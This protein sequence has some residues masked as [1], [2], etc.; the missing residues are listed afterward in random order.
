M[1]S[2][3]PSVFGFII[4]IKIWQEDDLLYLAWSHSHRVSLRSFIVDLQ[5]G[6]FIVDLLWER[7]IFP[8]FCYFK[9][10]IMDAS[11]HI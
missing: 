1:V 2:G 11:I 7:A 8:H 9:A 5:L 6:T 10:L 3:I 4:W